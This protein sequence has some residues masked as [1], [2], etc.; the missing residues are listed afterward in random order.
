MINV[1][2]L[3]N[4]RRKR[5]WTQQHL[6]DVADLSLRTVQRIESTGCCS[7]ESLLALASVLGVPSEDLVD[8]GETP[9][10][11]ARNTGR[12]RGIAGS[13][14]FIA[15]I[16]VAV[17]FSMGASA[18]PVLLEV[19]LSSSGESVSSVQLLSEEGETAEIRTG[20]GLRMEFSAKIASYE[21][22]RI[23][24]EVRLFSAVEGA[25]V[26]APGLLLEDRQAGEVRFE[27]TDGLPYQLKI[28]PILSDS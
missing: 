12:A 1:N 23:F 26:A 27:G 16:A 6:A 8:L 18:R 4:A 17:V 21:H 9:R 10:P 22:G 2:E 7:P 19:D 24:V 20:N 28:T 5:G 25:L 13:V 3:R 14:A 15:A 11:Q